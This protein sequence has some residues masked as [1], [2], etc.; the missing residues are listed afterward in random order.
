MEYYHI[1]LKEVLNNISNDIR[2]AED[3]AIIFSCV[4]KNIKVCFMNNM[5]YHYCVRDGSVTDLENSDYLVELTAF[6]KYAK[7]IFDA[8]EEREYLLRQ[9]G[10]YLLQE[11]KYAVN[12][13]L[14]LAIAGK[15]ICNEPYRLDYSSFFSEKKKI[16]LYG[17]GKVGTDYWKQLVDCK[18]FELCAWVDKNYGKYQEKE[19]DVR[20]VEYIQ[21]I[22]FDYILVAVNKQVVFEEIKK[23]LTDMGI[24]EDVIIWGRPYGA[25][26][27]EN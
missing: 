6:Y 16:V 11:A 17:A 24:A 23:E 1:V 27:K 12:T 21:E 8:H 14:G 5:Y 9:L 2:Y 20:S 26:C 15:P 3:K 4:F 25:L 19:M 22:K 7:K 18:N 10:K 13:K